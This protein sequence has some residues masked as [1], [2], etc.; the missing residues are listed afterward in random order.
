MEGIIEGE[1]IDK[2]SIDIESINIDKESTSEE[3]ACKEN[4]GKS[5]SEEVTDWFR[6]A[7]CLGLPTQWFFPNNKL[8]N[9]PVDVSTIC[10]GC[11][12]Q[13]QCLNY[14]I[15]NNIEFGIWGGLRE[16]HRRRLI[17]LHGTNTSTNFN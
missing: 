11:L 15:D 1:S 3:N 6:Y 13:Q 17:N 9:P 4:S 7:S 5:E 14:S 16:S 8:K 10:K 2:E 12:V